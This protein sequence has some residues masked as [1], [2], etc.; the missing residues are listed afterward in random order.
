[1]AS[2]LLYSHAPPSIFKNFDSASWTAPSLELT[3]LWE[4]SQSLPKG[5]FEITPVQAWFLLSQ[6]YEV[7]RVLRKL[8]GL[9]GG[10]SKLVGCWAFGAVM[11]ELKF[12]DVVKSVMGE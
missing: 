12:W 9:K 4:M 2:T 11:D 5:D 8:D 1:M 3:K 10:I 6:N 7:G